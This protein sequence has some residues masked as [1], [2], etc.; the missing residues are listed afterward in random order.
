[1]TVWAYPNWGWFL[2]L[3]CRPP[4]GCTLMTSHG[5]CIPWMWTQYWIDCLWCTVVKIHEWKMCNHTQSAH[6]L[7]KAALWDH[8][9]NITQWTTMRLL[10]NPRV[11]LTNFPLDRSY[12]WSCWIVILLRVVKLGSNKHAMK[13]Y[14]KCF[15]APVFVALT[16]TQTTAAW[17]WKPT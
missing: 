4:D 13:V 17:R 3:Q 7:I 14:I 16:W 9:Q 12:I 5:Y 11:S 6:W 1:M 10:N 2:V 8:C 15:I